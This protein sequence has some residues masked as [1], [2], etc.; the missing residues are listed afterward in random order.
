[1]ISQLLELLMVSRGKLWLWWSTNSH[2]RDT[3]HGKQS[4]ELSTG[5]I[6]PYPAWTTR[7]T[8]GIPSLEEDIWQLSDELWKKDPLL[9]DFTEAGAKQSNVIS[10][11]NSAISDTILC[12]SPAPAHRLRGL[13]W[14]FLARRKIQ[15]CLT[16]VHT[17][18]KPLCHIT[19]WSHGTANWGQRPCSS[20]ADSW[21]TLRRR[22]H[23][24]YH[25]PRCCICL[26]PSSM[27]LRQAGHS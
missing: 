6:L 15:N 10:D 12:P 3:Q 23:H 25:R 9:S 18:P 20:P 7:T 27:E 11:L 8:K 14:Q 4:P 16:S 22:F 24:C 13:R 5:L 2:H 1:M 21:P 17:S 26:A 19:D